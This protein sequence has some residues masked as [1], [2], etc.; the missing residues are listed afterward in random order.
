MSAWTAVRRFFADRA[1]QAAIDKRAIWGA[2]GDPYEVPVH[3]GV[4]VNQS[5]AARVTT[6]YRCHDILAGTLGSMGWGAFRK[7]GPA[8]LEVERPAPWLTSPN[9]ETTPFEAVER[10]GESLASDGNAFLLITARDPTGVLPIEWW[11]LNPRQ[12]TVVVTDSGRTV[13]DWYGTTPP[14]RLSRFGP[15]NPLGEVLHIRLR[16][17]GGARGM[18]PL[19]QARQAIGLAL[20]AE[21]SGARMFGK[22]MMSPW[23]VKLPAQEGGIARTDEHVELMRDKMKHKHGGPDK[24][25]EPIFLTGGAGLERIGITPE[26]AQF[27]ETRRFQVEEIARL[28]GI[29]PHMV[30]AVERTTSWGTG[31]E[32]QSLGFLRFTLLPYIVR[33]EQALSLLLPRGQFVKLNQRTL[34]RGDARSEAEVAT[35]LLTNGVV[36]FDYVAGL[37]ELAPRPGG[38]RYMVPA[39]MEVLEADGLKKP[40]QPVPLGGPNGNGRV[41][42]GANDGRA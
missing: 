5:T 6:V 17:G 2:G 40:P 15:D 21:Q 16:G 13:F 27:L 37:Y 28:Y 38:E 22:G 14:R 32:Q 3:A 24:S 11:T 29:P 20:V 8:S 25:W 33:I 12:V 42:E 35:K 9:P 26:E 39:N 31:I 19:E 30:G 18:S 10:I 34:L 7:Q 4:S 41:E 1:T 36:N 23:A